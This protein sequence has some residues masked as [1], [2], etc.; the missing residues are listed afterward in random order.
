M[1][2]KNFSKNT[3]YP[4]FIVEKGGII[5]K[6]SKQ[7]TKLTEYTRDELLNNN[8]GKVFKR[9]GIGTD[10]NMEN[11]NNRTDYFLF[12]KSLEVVF[13]KI[14]VIYE[15]KKKIYIFLEKSDLNL[16]ENYPFLNA[17]FLD[18]YYG[19]GIYSSDMTLLKANEKYVAYKDEPFNSMENCI[20]K[21]ISE[22]LT[23]FKGSSYEEIWNTVLQTQQTYNID[24]YMYEG[25]E[26]G[27]TYW[28]LSLIP[29]CEEN[30]IKY[31]VVMVVEITERVL[32]RKKAEQA[33]KIMKEQNKKIEA[34]INNVSD[35][36]F[37]FNNDNSITLLN[38]NS[39][40]FVYNILE[41]KEP[42]QDGY[43]YKNTKCLDKYGDVIEYND[44][45]GVRARNGEKIKNYFMTVKKTN[46]TY[47]YNIS[48]SPIYDE[49]ENIIFV[50]LC[51]HD[52]TEL[53]NNEKWVL[54]QKE[55]LRA[56]LNNMQDSIYVFDS[57]GN[58][59]V[60]NK[61]AKEELKTKY[62]GMNNIYKNAKNF[63]L[64][65]NEIKLEDMPQYRII[66]GEIIRD[67][68]ISSKVD[69]IDEYLS[70]SGSPVID[71]EGK[72]MYGIICSRDVTDFM[73][74]DQAL[75][76]TQ[77]KLLQAE[78]EKNEALEK[79]LE[80]KDE[81]VSFISHE[82]KTPLNVI[83]TAIQAIDHLC[84]NELSD[85]VKKYLK[86]IK[87]NTFRQLRLVNNLLD[88]TRAD[89]GRIK[90]N[91]KNI[92]IVFLTKAITESV[93]NYAFQKGINLTF[94]SSIEERIIAIDDEKY[95]R[96]LLNLLSN[97]IKFTPEGKSI[98]V[99]LEPKRSYI[100][101]E[102]KDNGI[103]IP[104]E[105]A[106]VIFERFGQVDSALSRQAEGTGIGLSLVKRFVEALG[107]SI[108]L[109]SSVGRGSTFTVLLPKQKMAEEDVEEEL[110]EFSD[111]RIVQTI[112]VEFS[113]IYS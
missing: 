86:M 25:L 66:N 52:I 17:L 5:V 31:C 48:A 69:N 38:D 68:I 97:A 70:I 8:I 46:K 10:I 61:V 107:G 13:V 4:I 105:K 42:G 103:G 18:D 102:V 21:H 77:S 1:D 22:F 23:G 41:Y 87:S 6:V 113:D 2:K 49:K 101:I 40:S 111:N 59:F 96:I 51:A 89:A 27:T 26:R 43:L 57:E 104:K 63:D 19:V 110:V 54:E 30:N 64:D 47:H 58:N 95:E 92:D 11:I 60:M 35:A 14:K 73:K 108:S 81:F 32:H 36:M 53:V 39:K 44:L 90:I 84:G 16:E 112:D 75:K 91:K 34:V 28:Q 29:L 74:N 7:F 45:P 88:I 3:N 80:M 72:F 24:E 56:L 78:Q 65:G 76:E 109:K 12:K 9:L 20:G 82:F 93:H 37:L 50:L 79:A 106:D 85:R 67:Y 15:K 33:T 94:S 71:N 99:K 98:T 62:G 55:Q 100:S 83:N